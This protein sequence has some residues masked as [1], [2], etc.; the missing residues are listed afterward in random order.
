M[1][2]RQLYERLVRPHRIPESMAEEEGSLIMR[3]LH[4]MLDVSE[5]EQDDKTSQI[6]PPESDTGERFKAR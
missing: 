4:E 6:A 2:L 3:R 1:L 5:V